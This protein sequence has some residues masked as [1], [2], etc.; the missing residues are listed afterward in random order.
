MTYYKFTFDEKN[1]AIT[2]D[3]YSNF[4]EMIIRMKPI[5]ALKKQFSRLG[6][7]NKLI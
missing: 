4:I 7:P 3:Y 1:Y 2:V 6:I 5:K